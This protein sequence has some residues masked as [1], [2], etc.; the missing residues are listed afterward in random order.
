MI[1]NVLVF[2]LQCILE[3]VFSN[4]AYEMQF[5][6]LPPRY[7]QGCFA[8]TSINM[9][10]VHKWSKRIPYSR[11]LFTVC[12]TLYA[13]K[14]K[15]LVPFIWYLNVNFG[16]VNLV[17]NQRNGS[18]LILATRIRLQFRNRSGSDLSNKNHS[19]PKCKRNMFY[20]RKFI[21]YREC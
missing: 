5:S 9:Y 11:H 6:C 20:K 21:L 17:M 12:N 13:D 10:V 4:S 18:N 2:F 19:T 15:S 3:V 1:E 8:L 14:K 7:R 16:F